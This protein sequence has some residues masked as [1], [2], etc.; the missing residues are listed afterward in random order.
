M[1][2]KNIEI[3]LVVITYHD[4]FLWTLKHKKAEY[5]KSASVIQISEEDRKSLGVSSGEAITLMNKLG[6]IEVRV[7]VDKSCPE[8]FGFMPKSSVVNRLISFEEELPNS[9]WIDTIAG[10]HTA[11]DK[12]D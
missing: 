5:H 1:S 12:N 9:K 3:P 7:E 10:V 2:A 8:G 4:A 6:R 11:Q